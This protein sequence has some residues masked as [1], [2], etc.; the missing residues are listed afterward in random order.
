MN[1]E[2]PNVVIEDPAKRKIV[3]TVIGLFALALSAVNAGFGIAV[4]AEVVE[5]PLWLAITNGVFPIIAAGLGYTASRN[6]PT[7]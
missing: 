7:P 2:T 5:F 3:Y 1:N 6:V 4:A